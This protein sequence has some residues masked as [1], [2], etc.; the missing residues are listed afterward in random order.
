MQNSL[1]V[2]HDF[3]L[4]QLNTFG[5]DAHARHYVRV[6]GA[7]DLAAALADRHYIM[8]DGKVVDMIAGSELS[9]RADSIARYLAV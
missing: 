4:K 5:I 2:Q 6:T 1:S 9:A 8:E 3:S 7:S